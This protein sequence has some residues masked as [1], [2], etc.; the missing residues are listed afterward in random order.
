MLVPFSS[1]KF[2]EKLPKVGTK[3]VGMSDEHKHFPTSAE[4]QIKT[5][6]LPPLKELL[7]I[8]EVMNQQQK[9]LL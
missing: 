6:M 4:P 1:L 2:E 3:P 9:K 7:K 8:I 5:I